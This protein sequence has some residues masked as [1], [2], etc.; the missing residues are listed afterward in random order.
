MMPNS[1][2]IVRSGGVGMGFGRTPQR[3]GRP[4]TPA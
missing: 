4:P 3:P 1:A 2:S